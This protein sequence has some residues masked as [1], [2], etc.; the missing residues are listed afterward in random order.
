MATDLGPVDEKRAKLVRR[1]DALAHLLDNSIPIPGTGTRFGLDAVIGLVPGFGDAAG[2]LLSCYFVLEA[3]RLGAGF[4]V[5]LRMLLNIGIET[6]VGAIPF[7]GDL[8]DAGWKANDRNMRLLHHAI[9]SP[10]AARKSSKLFVLLVFLLLAAVFAGI[11]ALIWYVL[12]LVF[13]SGTWT[14]R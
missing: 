13:S 3:A 8:F 10:D 6:V 12:Q 1:L 7:I 11:L 14:G 9:D 2:A 5:I 4:S